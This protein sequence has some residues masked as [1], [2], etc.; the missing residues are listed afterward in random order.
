[1]T[2]PAF[3]FYVSNFIEGTMDMTDTEVGLYIRLLCAQWSRGSLPNDDTQLM[4]FSRGA[5]AADLAVVKTKF[6][7]GADG[8][9]RNARMEIVRAE[10]K[11]W[12][13][14]SRNGGRASG[15]KRAGNSEWGK[16]LAQQRTN[17]RTKERTDNEPHTDN[18]NEPTTNT[19]NSKLL[20]PS[21]I[22]CSTAKSAHAREKVFIE[23]CK[24]AFGPKAMANWGGRWRK[25]YR[26]DP[27]RAQRAVAA[28]ISDSREKQ[29]ENPGGYAFDLYKRFP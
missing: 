20:T 2:G 27:D 18:H 13:K 3:Q 26:E 12:L 6:Q 16:A 21:P 29:I 25:L 7:L 19:L 5:T 24:E 14:K 1:M 17:Q 4:R 15:S 11:S 23:H 22:K 28:T 9:L 8:L 10:K